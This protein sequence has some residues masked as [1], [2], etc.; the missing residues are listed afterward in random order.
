MTGSTTVQ[1]IKWVALCVAA[2]L[3]AGPIGSNVNAQELWDW[4]STQVAA[5]LR[6]RTALLSAPSVRPADAWT[7]TKIVLFAN[8]YSTW[9][10]NKE[11]AEQILMQSSGGE[12][13]GYH[14]MKWLYH[15]WRAEWRGTGIHDFFE[16]WS[17]DSLAWVFA[18]RDLAAALRRDRDLQFAPHASGAFNPALP[19]AI[20]NRW[21]GVFWTVG[22]LFLFLNVFWAY[23]N[24]GLIRVRAQHFHHPLLQSLEDQITRNAPDNMTPLLISALE[25]ELSGEK[26]SQRFKAPQLIAGLSRKQRLLL[27][28][29]LDGY[30]MEDCAEFLQVSKGHLYN[31]RWELRRIMGL[32]EHE[33]FKEVLKD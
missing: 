19:E 5:E 4:D 7:W 27:H 32:G 3:G 8:D 33:A 6:M 23:R 20:P 12:V 10:A 24:L 15:P 28:L 2:I 18:E 17:E 31:Q 11:R 22:V 1:M 26:W 14:G 25:F 29:I 21:N 30:N 16:G 9:R 13:D